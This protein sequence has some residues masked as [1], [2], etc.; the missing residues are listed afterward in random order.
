MHV[1]SFIVQ[2]FNKK[3]DCIL[4]DAFFCGTFQ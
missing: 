2:H 3:L 1:K 4:K